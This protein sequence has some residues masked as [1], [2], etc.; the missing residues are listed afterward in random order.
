MLRNHFNP[1][2]SKHEDAPPVGSGSSA[3]LLAVVENDEADQVSDA[4]KKDEEDETDPEKDESDP[5]KDAPLAP[6]AAALTPPKLSAFERTALRAFG[7]GDLIARVE[8]AEGQA[9]LA[10]AEA[11]RLTEENRKLTGR[12][13]ALE[14]ETPKQVAAAVKGRENEVQRAVTAELSA[15]GLNPDAAPSQIAA[16]ATPEAMLEHFQTLKGAEKTTYWRANSKALKTAEASMK[17]EKSK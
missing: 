4:E 14:T 2:F 10:K 9:F 15:L 11:A 8:L 6:E 17:A 3:P 16:E 12:L 13:S 7:K 5:E 1:L